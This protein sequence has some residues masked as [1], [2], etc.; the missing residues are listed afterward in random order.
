VADEHPT[1]AAYGGRAGDDV[2]PVALDL[3]RSS[4]RDFIVALRRYLRRRED[5]APPD[6][7]LQIRGEL[8]KVY[9]EFDQ[10]LVAGLPFKEVSEILG[11]LDGALD[12]LDRYRGI[13]SPHGHR[14]DASVPERDEAQG[15]RVE[16]RRALLERLDRVWESVR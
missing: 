15:V 6:T 14:Q 9:D 5:H 3:L 2:G 16:R 8:N 11:A 1:F 10:V 13:I 4:S 12:A 7:L